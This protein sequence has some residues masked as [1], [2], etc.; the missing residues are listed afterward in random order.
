MAQVLGVS[1]SVISDLKEVRQTSQP[2]YTNAINSW[3]SLVDMNKSQQQNKFNN[4]ISEI[5]DLHNN[6]N[7]VKM[8]IEALTSSM[9]TN[10]YIKDI[11]QKYILCSNTF[12]N[13]VGLKSNYKPFGKTDTDFFSI[14]EAKINTKQDAEVLIGGKSIKNIEMHIPGSRKKKWG[15]A[16]KYPVIDINNNTIGLIGIFIDITEKKKTEEKNDMLIKLL[17]TIPYSIGAAYKHDYF[18]INKACEI[19]IGYS[20]EEII[21]GGNELIDKITHYTPDVEKLNKEAARIGEEINR[22]NIARIFKV[23]GNIHWIHNIGI[24]FY[25][26]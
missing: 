17:D 16:S 18:F 8:I 10:F 24:K 21:Q 11:Q 5:S 20:R 3:Q 2:D 14:N 25:A 1:V 12:L 23:D 13:T 26:Q 19:Q 7:Q 15:F 6:M 9:E 4:F 22:N